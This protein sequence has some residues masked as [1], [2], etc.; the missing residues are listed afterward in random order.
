[1]ALTESQIR[2]MRRFVG[3][4]APSDAELE[5][6]L[7][8]LGDMD[9]VVREV[10]DERLSN[11]ES[12]PA[13]FSIPGSYSQDQGANIR[14]LRRRLTEIPGKLQFWRPTPRRAR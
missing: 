3:T 14:S 1:M 9:E 7:T 5:Q 4:T 6:R 2:Y 8:R 11:L 12:E 13:Q 10:L